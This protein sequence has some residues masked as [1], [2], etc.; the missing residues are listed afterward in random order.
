MLNSGSWQCDPQP[1]LPKSKKDY[2][3]VYRIGF[4]Y[5]EFSFL[6]EFLYDK[7]EKETMWFIYPY[8][9][10]FKNN[11]IIF[12]DVIKSSKRYQR[13]IYDLS[14]KNDK[15]NKIL[16]TFREGKIFYSSDLCGTDFKQAI[17][18]N[19]RK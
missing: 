17:D 8:Q 14:F 15:L 16:S 1:K 13:N 3:V 12:S 5:K 9:K 11:L 10:E 7:E 4:Y 2:K 19:I 6:G 18:F